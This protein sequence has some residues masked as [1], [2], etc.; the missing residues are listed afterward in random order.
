MFYRP[1]RPKKACGVCLKVSWSIFSR[2]VDVC[3]DPAEFP[4]GVKKNPAQRMPLQLMITPYLFFFR[5]SVGDLTGTL[6]LF[7]D[8]CVCFRCVPV[9]SADLLCGSAV[10]VHVH[11]DHN[12]PV[13]TEETEA[14]RSAATLF[15]FFQNSCVTRGF[16]ELF[17]LDFFSFW[18][19]DTSNSKV[20]QGEQQ[21]VYSNIPK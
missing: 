17:T 11:C 15:F 4:T 18:N 16:A 3:G 12:L 21:Q 1:P 13:H 6:L 10:H 20:F 9:C 5:L 2:W 7:W 8:R 14:K 19:I